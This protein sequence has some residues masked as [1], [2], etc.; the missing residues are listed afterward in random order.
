M[1]TCIPCIVYT[2][3]SLVVGNGVQ[4][5]ILVSSYDYVFVYD[6]VNAAA[7]GRLLARLHSTL[8]AQGCEWSKPAAMTATPLRCCAKG[9]PG[10]SVLILSCTTATMSSC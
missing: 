5:T 1:Y 7:G 2:F 3:S 8:D 10:E 4:C 9:V 6:G